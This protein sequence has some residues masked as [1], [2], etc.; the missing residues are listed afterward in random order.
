MAKL[1]F[2]KFSQNLGYQNKYI[3]DVP[4][5]IKPGELVDIVF[6][7]HGLG[8][9][10]KDFEQ[11]NVE[12][13]ATEYKQVHVYVNAHNSYY[14]NTLRNKNYTAYVGE[15]ILTNITD[16][17]NLKINKKSII[18]ISMGGYGALLTGLTYNFD[19]IASLSGAVLIE[20]RLK[21]VKDDR[22]D[23]LLVKVKDNQSIPYLLEKKKNEN[24]KIFC[25]CGKNDFLYND[26]LNVSKYIAK[27]YNSKIL[28]DEGNHDFKSWNNVM[29]DVF[30]C[31][32]KGDA[33]AKDKH[34]KIQ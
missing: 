12:K 28:F 34:W 27:N 30:E 11:Y 24:I 4:D 18:G 16:Y 22:F 21:L 17:L 15:E 32:N 26:N 23:G 3:V 1:E 14:L 7:L 5:N 33:N 31:F 10:Y 13:Y 2:N 8:G 19:N 6:L 9:T 25:Y 20:N 29:R